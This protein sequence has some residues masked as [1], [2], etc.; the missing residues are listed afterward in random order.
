M[1]NGPIRPS[2]LDGIKRFAK[3][4]KAS[5]GLKHVDAL[6]AAAVA[7]GFQNYAHAR[8]HLS[9]ATRAVSGHLAYITVNWRLR[10]T[11]ES[12]QETL[13][14]RLA[15]PLDQLVKPAHLKRGLAGFRFGAADHLTHDYLADSQ[16]EA[17]RWACAAARTLAFM[18]ATGLRPSAGR[19]RAYPRGDFQNAVPGMDHSS[20][21]YDPVTRAH[22]LAD[23]PYHRAVKDIY[24]DR[25]A[26]ARRHGWE[27]VK[28]S[29]R[30]M[31]YPDGGSVLYLAADK[32]K[33]CSLVP[34][35]TALDA[36]PPPMVEADWNGVSAPP[37]PLFV[38][39]AARAKADTPRPVPKTS[40]KRSPRATVGYRPPFSRN[41]R[42][43]P[44]KRMPIEAHAEVGKLLESVIE[45][46]HR[47]QGVHNRLNMVRTD[48]DDWVQCE[49]NRAELS[50]E[51][52]FGLYYRADN[53]PEADGLPPQALK[54]RHVTNLEQAKCILTQHYP[55]CV[56][57]RGT[58]KSI[59]AAI[60][61]LRSWAI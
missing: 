34:I 28:P 60:K 30:G 10:K 46:T 57:L 55:E 29:W 54:D 15:T 2:T 21:W 1:S 41:E 18:E 37:S 45:R 26:W 12:G 36:L 49:Y 16:S 20:V 11:R 59:D 50:D 7:A 25:L 53:D 32:A 22:V 8:R 51:R 6:D 39:P 3:T 58:L 40:G 42:R 47:R 13:P 27:I 48:L 61:S 14:I 56:P 23:E 17:R 24:E 19:S 43:R 33:G 52:F 9:G 38:S 44:A 35:V 4:L 31:Y 5:Q